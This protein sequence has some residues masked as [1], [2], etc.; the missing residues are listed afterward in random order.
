MSLK[1][2]KYPF[3]SAG[4]ADWYV[5]F[6]RF[7]NSRQNRYKNKLVREKRRDKSAWKSLAPGYGLQRRS[8]NRN[9]NTDFH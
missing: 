3:K 5:E 4:F 6:K 1:G 2:K 8:D 7:Q 9:Q